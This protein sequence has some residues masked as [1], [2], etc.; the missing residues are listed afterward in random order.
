MHTLVVE[1]KNHKGW[2]QSSL[3]LLLTFLSAESHSAPCLMA[4]DTFKKKK[5][6]EK[7]CPQSVN[8]NKNNNHDERGV[9]SFQLINEPVEATN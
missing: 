5:M 4:R 7:W 8:N 6:N 9:Q 3:R 1:L 2:C